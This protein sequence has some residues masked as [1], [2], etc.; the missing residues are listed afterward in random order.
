MSARL[1]FRA[2]LFCLLAVF[3]AVFFFKTILWDGLEERHQALAAH[4][5]KV[6]EE[7]NTVAPGVVFV[8][9]M[10]R[11]DTVREWEAL[12][13]ELKTLR[14]EQQVLFSPRIA[15][16]TLRA[17]AVERDYLLYLTGRLVKENENDPTAVE[18]FARAQELHEKNMRLIETVPE[19]TGDC[20]WNAR[21]WY[22]QGSEYVASLL[23]V[24]K[25]DSSE[26]AEL[27][28]KAI[29]RFRKVFSCSPKNSEEYRDAEVAI[30]KLYERAKK[31][32]GDPSP[33]E[34]KNKK[35]SLKQKL[36][37]FPSH[38]MKPGTGKDERR[39]GRH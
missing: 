22:F 15:A 12:A 39:E 13:Q 8:Q 11:A 28:G 31:N 38:E 29:D 26:A 37:F 3:I 2:G 25:E 23:F 6:A 36:P 10:A 35:D 30:E 4:E 20:K 19:L 5:A 16:E 32:R 33:S 27:R 7:K 9:K 34:E 24:E 18:Y 21:L 1:K 14:K 17:R